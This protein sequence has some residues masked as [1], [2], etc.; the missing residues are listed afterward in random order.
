MARGRRVAMANADRRV[1][2][3]SLLRNRIAVL[4]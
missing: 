3:G 4:Y 1:P 2:N